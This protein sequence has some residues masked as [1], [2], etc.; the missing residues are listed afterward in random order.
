MRAVRGFE[1]NSGNSRLCLKDVWLGWQ[2]DTLNKSEMVGVMGG[3]IVKL[4]GIWSP[5]RDAPLGWVFREGVTEEKPLP[6]KEH[7]PAGSPDIKRP[8]ENQFCLPTA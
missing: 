6:Q 4:D 7:H 5:L 1:K 8:M 3:W 2:C